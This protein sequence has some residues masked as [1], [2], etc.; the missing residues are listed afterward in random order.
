M[1]KRVL[2]TLLIILF[3]TTSAYSQDSDVERLLSK[4]DYSSALLF[5]K[6]TY[7]NDTSNLNRFYDLYLYYKDIKNPNNDFVSALFYAQLYKEQDKKDKTINLSSFAE[8]TLGVI[9]QKK[10]VDALS[11][12][13]AISDDYPQLQQ[14]ATRIR[15]RLAFEQTEQTASIEAYE[16]FIRNYPNAIQ[17]DQARSWLNEHLIQ[18]ILKSND[19]NKLRE[20]INTT[21][22]D[23]YRKQA[24]EQLD[25]TVFKQV[26]QE[27]TV[28]AYDRYIKEFPDG[29]YIV[30]AKN[31]RESAQYDKYVNE[32]TIS[33]MLFYL[34]NTSKTDKNYQLV[35]DKLKLYA[36]LHYSIPAML[37]VDSIEHNEDDL[38]NFAKNYVSDLSLSSINRLTEA[39]PDLKTAEYIVE[40]EKKASSLQSLLNKQ[41]LTVEDYK[42][43]KSLL[44]N[45]NAR[46]SALVFQRF[47]ELNETL[48]KNKMINFNL[49][50]DFH[51]L[52]FRQAKKM[53]L[54]LV[55][56]DAV[57]NNKKKDI[58][59]KTLGLD[60]QANDVFVSED[61]SVILFSTSGYDGYDAYPLSENKD[62]Y[63][64]VFKEGKWQKPLPLNRPLNSRFNDTHPIL[65]KDKK[66]LWFSSDRD[67]NFGKLDIYVSYRE[68][69]K[70]WNAWTEPI[71]LGEDVNTADD[72]YV[73][74][75]EDNI[76][77]LSQDENFAEDSHIFLE[78]NTK[79]NIVT[80]KITSTHKDFSNSKLY[81]YNS[82]DF[83]LINIA[84]PNE[85]GYFAFIKPKTNYTV[86][87]QK[88]NYYT[89]MSNE[90]N[91]TLYSIDELATNNDIITIPS[92]FNPSN[93]LQ[94]SKRGEME[95]TLL[96]NVFKNKPYILTLE[97]HSN[98]DYKKD[99]AKELSEK[100]ADLVRD[101]LVKKC[102]ID[103]TK[104]ITSGLGTEKVVQG[105]EGI[106]C[107]DIS[108]LIR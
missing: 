53:E 104:L 44:N 52:A 77:V 71:L 101:F 73:V 12:Y 61:K 27:N 42:K 7:N 93:P 72:D 47:Y 74:R 36:S 49:G 64:S 69:D 91:I 79:L 11:R 41:K 33:D 89:P 1:K 9:Y 70:D 85:K 66:T 10:D 17:V 80:G 90:N 34:R 87:L 55:L 88:S 65:S 76:L 5:I 4:G 48:P 46:Q 43:N 3:G 56:T 51:Y 32:G 23:T 30:M 39:F 75:L 68:D 96:S 31:K 22:N 105:W 28:E 24:L 99:S 100:Q 59:I 102:G 108:I 62:I 40:A 107:V 38:K 2:Y 67:L 18:S 82:K 94:L 83:S 14:E 97:I 57:A 20:F 8:E 103:D 95:L 19:I 78:G 60:I 26:L 92:L 21:N 54:D 35:F 50:Y 16:N 106:D 13:I 45:L 84:I 37:V 29:E 15:D 81:I 25:K 98:K 63:Y 58:D 6:N 86:Y